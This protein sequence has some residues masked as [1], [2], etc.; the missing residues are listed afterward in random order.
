M[1]RHLQTLMSASAAS[2]LTLS[3]L[4]Q[5]TQGA[6]NPKPDAPTGAVAPA[7]S[8]RTGK[9]HGSAKASDVLGMTVK[10]KQDEVL[11]EVKEL[12][13][14]VESGRIIF[15]VL[16]TGGYLG[17][18]DT[19]MAVPP[20]ALHHDVTNKVIHLDANKDTLKDAPFFEMAKWTEHSNSKALAKIYHYYGEDAAFNFVLPTE[21]LTDGASKAEGILLKTHLASGN[22]LIPESGL[23]LLQ[24][25]SKVIG[26]PVKN[27]Q[28]EKLGKVENV[29]LDI[30]SGRILALIVSSGGFLGMADELSAIP[31]T[32]VRYTAD[33][34][35][36][37][38][39]ASKEL[40][41]KAPHFKAHEWPNFTHPTYADG[42]YRAYKVM[43]YFAINAATEVDN[44]ARKVR[45]RDSKT[46]TPLDQG[47]SKADVETTASIR[48]AIMGTE[49]L[50]TNAKNIKIITVNGRVT[51]RGP[52]NTIEE[53]RVIQE[54][55]GKIVHTDHVDNQLEV[56]LT[57]S[58]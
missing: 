43:P 26:T 25:A 44:T 20:G 41:S 17:V 11:G 58:H 27:L 32:A 23:A 4:A 51:L 35:S 18:G 40:L 16:S 54:I 22:T 55:A 10:N 53:K 49:T 1:K 48:K 14:D 3:A 38:L 7:G 29:L 31:P 21:A 47:S 46:L 34:E 28:E 6:K 13:V 15:V 8:P 5:D 42:V 12:A 24:K 39:D 30:S 56:Q 50:S 2:F 19:L 33:M 45:D 9:L 52:V 36:L 37:Q 57:G